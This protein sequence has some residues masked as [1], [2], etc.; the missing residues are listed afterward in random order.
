MFIQNASPKAILTDLSLQQ[1]SPVALGTI[2]YFTGGGLY[3]S[4]ATCICLLFLQLLFL[5]EVGGTPMTFLVNDNSSLQE[6]QF[7]S[8]LHIL[9]SPTDALVDVVAVQGLGS[10]YPHTWMGKKQTRQAWFSHSK[11]EI[12]KVMWLKEYLPKDFPAARIMAFEYNSRWLYEADF[13]GLG[14][15]ASALL[16]A[17]VE[18]RQHSFSRPILFIGHSYGGLVV[19]QALVLSHKFETEGT[20][21]RKWIAH[22]ESGIIFLG[23][24]HQ[25]SNYGMVALVLSFIYRPLG[26]NYTQVLKLLSDGE[27]LVQLDNEFKEVLSRG[28][29]KRTI[30]FYETKGQ[31]WTWAFGPLVTRLSARLGQGPEVAMEC[32]HN[33]MNKFSERDE[34]YEKFIGKLKPVYNFL[35]NPVANEAVKDEMRKKLSGRI[36]NG[37]AYSSTEVGGCAAGTRETIL[38]K[39][40]DWAH[41]TTQQKVCW[42]TGMAGTGKTT[43][44]Y[45]LC[46]R[47]EADGILGASFFCSTTE[48]ETHNIRHLLPTLAYALGASSQKMADALLGALKDKDVADMNLKDTFTTL[49]STPASIDTSPFHGETRVIVLD[50]FDQVKDRDRVEGILSLILEH[51][52]AVALK[53]FISSRPLSDKFKMTPQLWRFDLYNRPEEEVRRDIKLYVQRRLGEL[54]E[55]LGDKGK[56]WPAQEQVDAIVDRA[57]PLFIYASTVC[58]YIGE[59]DDSQIKRRL[60]AAI[61][62]AP[63]KGSTKSPTDKLYALYV[64]IIDVASKNCNEDIKEVLGLI[65]AARDHLSIQ[66]IASLLFSDDGAESESRVS[67]ALSPLRSVLSVP[68]DENEGVR[69]I[70]TSFLDFLTDPTRLGET[71]YHNP[72]ECHRNLATNCLYLMEKVLDKDEIEGLQD[73][74][75]PMDKVKERVYISSALEYSCVHWISHVVE[76]YDL[77]LGS[78]NKMEADV[79]RFFEV[80]V[81]RWLVHMSVLGK[82]SYAAASLRKLELHSQASARVRKASVEARRL[83]SQSHSVVESYPLQIYYSALMRI[84]KK[85]DIVRFRKDWNWEVTWGLAEDW[86]R[87]EGVLTLGSNLGSVVFSNDGRMVATYARG[88]ICIWGVEDLKELCVMRSPDDLTCIALSSDGKSVAAGFKTDGIQVWDVETKNERMEDFSRGSISCIAFI[89]KDQE[90]ICGSFESICR[91][92]VKTN[93][94]LTDIK[95][96]LEGQPLSFSRDGNRAILKGESHIFIIDTETGN[97]ISTLDIPGF[98]GKAAAFSRDGEKVVSGSNDGTIRI[99]DVQSGNEGARLIGHVGT[100]TSVAFSGDDQRIVSGS[101]DT[102]VRIWSVS[103]GKEEMK[104]VGHTGGVVNSADLEPGLEERQSSSEDRW[105]VIALAL[106]SDGQRVFYAGSRRVHIRNVDNGTEERPLIVERD[107]VN[108]LAILNNGKYVAAAYGKKLQIHSGDFRPTTMGEH[109]D[110]ILSVAFSSSSQK[111]ATGSRDKTIRI[112]D[113]KVEDE[114]DDDI[115]RDEYEVGDEA[116]QDEVKDEDEDEGEDDDD[117]SHNEKKL[118][119]HEDSVWSVSFSADGS[120]LVSGSSDHTIRIW[121]L[122][123]EGAMIKTLRG[124]TGPVL[125]VAF[126]SDSQ[127]V[128]SGSHDGTVRVWDVE[129]G[130]VKQQRA[131]ESSIWSVAFSPTNLKVVSGCNCHRI[132]IWDLEGGKVA[133]LEGHTDAVISVAFSPNQQ[134]VV[135][136]SHDTTVRLWDLETGKEERRIIGHI[137]SVQLV[138]FQEDDTV[139]SASYDGSCRTWDVQTGKQKARVNIPGHQVQSIALSSDDRLLAVGL[140]ST[141]R[142]LDVETEDEVVMQGHIDPVGSIAFSHNK[143]KILSVSDDGIVRT[144]NIEK[145]EEEKRLDFGSRRLYS[146]AFSPDSTIVALGD[147]FGTIYFWNVDTGAMEEKFRSDQWWMSSI[148]FIDDTHLLLRSR[149]AIR[150]WNVETGEEDE[151]IPDMTNVPIL[152]RDGWIYPP[153]TSAPSTRC[154]FPPDRVSRKVISNH[155]CIVFGLQLGESVI[156]KFKESRR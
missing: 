52:G 56:G 150:I 100:V 34:R 122:E 10:A 15:H 68:N 27:R 80:R 24:P 18:Q 6:K 77:K 111:V 29:T 64:Q 11:P 32:N 110:V 148:S 120:K 97:Q 112:W 17:L 102:S 143:E 71:Y 44:A 89:E 114:G 14:E 58:S 76:V 119:G 87:C 31:A 7:I 154:W 40:I 73:P 25:G 156:V 78:A 129:T 26:G 144:W 130:E 59:D 123:T 5:D 12:N 131:Y 95:L 99:F 103:D 128:V 135:S 65:V 105:R 45:T 37:S 83:T 140:D 36:I 42:M 86:E 153:S 33:E 90:V 92:S 113:P 67:A 41:G 21:H 46:E 55:R 141:I 4:G 101:H 43:I 13:Q 124:H 74:Y 85:S 93:E 81:L 66:S 84:P 35:T 149:D 9:V 23:T 106:S 70:H 72:F 54:A 79:T 116:E 125:S 39:L 1:L 88:E 82:L 127:K 118:T 22:A 117:D 48:D 109:D 147:F 151:S 107:Y 134:K 91:Y 19:K 142:I 8:R 2:V 49:I 28:A 3:I 69:V 126:S 62:K 51:A 16:D 115:D 30:C 139:F 136:G 60:K 108:T 50:G 61:D 133:V 137:D 38:S 121:D 63:V 155:S 47:L 146:A 20:D 132:Y 75:S 94:R 145:R 138:T 53:F 152:A 57:N 96:K 104:L 98:G